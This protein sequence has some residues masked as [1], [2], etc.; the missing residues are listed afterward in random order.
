MKTICTIIRNSVYPSSRPQKWKQFICYMPYQHSFLTTPSQP[1]NIHSTLWS[2]QY[3]LTL[4]CLLVEQWDT[5]IRLE[6]STAMEMKLS[7]N[8]FKPNQQFQFRVIAL[9]RHGISVPSEPSDYLST[10]GGYMYGKRMVW[11]G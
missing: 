10:L 5:L 6:N 2:I 1:L 7:F 8:N 9:N 4:S 11:S 3:N